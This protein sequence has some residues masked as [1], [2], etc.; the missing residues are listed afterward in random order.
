[1]EANVLNALAGHKESWGEAVR[2]CL[3]VVS[4]GG[5]CRV[6]RSMAAK[7]DADD[8]RQEVALGVEQCWPRF[9]GH[10]VGEFYCLVRRVAYRTLCAAE[11]RYLPEC[12]YSAELAARLRRAGVSL[13][14]DLLASE[15]P[16]PEQVAL[17]HEQERL[18]R[19]GLATL[20]VRQ[21]QVVQLRIDGLS[22]DEIA[23]FLDSTV[24]SVRRTWR[25]AKERLKHLLRDDTAPG[26]AA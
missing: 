25:D 10:S 19:H 17:A 2:L 7:F 1:L 26:T 13:L 15:D 24:A 3:A 22:L 5:R 9:R 18:V 20:G 23:C 6:G 4:A 16:T 11:Q 8:F 21:Q 12:G 14:D